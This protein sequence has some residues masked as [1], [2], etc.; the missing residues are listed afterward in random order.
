MS[1][2]PLSATLNWVQ[3]RQFIGANGSGHHLLVDGNPDS[4]TGPT[5]M[6]LV[7]LGMGGCTSYDVVHILSKSRQNVTNCVT[8]LSAERAEDVPTVF[9]RIHVHFEVSGQGLDEEKVARAVALSADKYCSASIMLTRGG[10][11]VTHD[12]EITSI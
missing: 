6:E 2:Q 11:E 3:D 7:L 8:R 9:T 4:N 5:P 12:F 1:N 10:V